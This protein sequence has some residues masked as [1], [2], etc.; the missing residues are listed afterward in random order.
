MHNRF[1]C[2]CGLG[3]LD[4]RGLRKLIVFL[5]ADRLAP[6]VCRPFTRDLDR[7]VDK[8]AV[9]RRAV[10]VLD[11]R[12]D[13]HNVA[14]VQLARRLARF[15][16]PAA[17]AGAEQDL[18]AAFGGMV[19]VPVVAAGRLKGHVA[20]GDTLGGEHIEVALADKILRKSGVLRAAR[21]YCGSVKCRHTY[22]P[23]L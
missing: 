10:P 5:V 23:F 1:A 19:D 3:R 16:V 20:D 22:H 14:G 4:A 2:F 9:L 8:P 15:L 6:L 17:A 18:A 13:D 21:K 12:R 11:V 7:K